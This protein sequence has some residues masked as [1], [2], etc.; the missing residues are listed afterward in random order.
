MH[1]AQ[2]PTVLGKYFQVVTSAFFAL[3]VVLGLGFFLFL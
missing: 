2:T 1:T 3:F